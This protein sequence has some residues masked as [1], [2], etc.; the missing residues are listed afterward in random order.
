MPKEIILGVT[1]AV[2][3]GII[4]SF[5]IPGLIELFLHPPQESNPEEPK[6][7]PETQSIPS[8]PYDAIKNPSNRIATVSI[9][10]HLFKYDLSNSL[11]H[12]ITGSEKGTYSFELTFEPNNEVI[13]KDS[14]IW[15]NNRIIMWKPDI[16]NDFK[17]TQIVFS[18]K[19]FPEL[20]TINIEEL[21]RTKINN[22]NY[23]EINLKIVFEEEVKEFLPHIYIPKKDVWGCELP[24]LFKESSDNNYYMFKPSEF[25]SV[26]NNQIQEIPI[27][28]NLKNDKA[29]LLDNRWWMK[30]K[31]E[32]L[33]GIE[34]YEI[35]YDGNYIVNIESELTYNSLPEF[36]LN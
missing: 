36:V 14:D 18:L 12:L 5:I 1:I 31:T 2:I 17:L 27:L 7:L 32:R 28:C 30:I 4:L 35:S 23:A 22:K 21:G 6:I 11:L 10:E 3:A 8:N 15:E 25:I 19:E 29:V 34:E 16:E 33:Y 24:E 26:G 13:R 20:F 9:I